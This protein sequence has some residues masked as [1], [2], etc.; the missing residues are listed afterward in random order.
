VST[1]LDPTSEQVAVGVYANG[2]DL[3][4]AGTSRFAPYAEFVSR[5][6]PDG[7]LR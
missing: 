3:I 7:N 2:C 5:R 4:V 6:A 1:L